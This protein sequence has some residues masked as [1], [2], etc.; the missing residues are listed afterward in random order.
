MPVRRTYIRKK[1][2]KRR[3][4]GLPSWSDKLLQEVLRQILDA[5]YEPRFSQHS[6]GFRPGRGCHTALQEMTQHWRGVKWYVEGDICSFFDRIDH[7]ILVKILRE[8]IHDNRFIG[9]I[10]HLLQ[11]GYMEE[12][13]FN[14]TLSGVPQ[15]GVV[16]P[17]LSNL[18]LD[19]LDKYVETVLT[20]AYTRGKRRK[21]SPPYVKLTKDAWKAKKRGDR[22]T[23]RQLNKQAQA[24][25]SRDPHAPKFRRLWYCRYADDWL[26][27]FTGPKAEAE[28]IK[29]HLAHFLREELGLELSEEKT[30]ITH[31]RSDVA[32]FLGYEIHTLQADDKHDHRGQRCING[33]L[34][35]RVPKAVIQAKC[36]KY[37]R[38]GKP[39]HLPQRL[40]DTPY[41]IVV[42]YQ[43][44][45]RGLVQDYRLAY[46]LHQLAKLKRVMEVSLAKTLA[47]KLKTSCAAIF[48]RFKTEQTNAYGTYK[49]LEVRV[50]RGPDKK[51]LVAH[52]GGIPL[53]WSKWVSISETIEP[54][55]SQRSEVVQ[56]LLAEK[57]ELCGATAK[58]EAH[59]I[60][61]LADLTLKGRRE[62][63]KWAQQMIARRRKSLMVCQKCHHDIHS[64]RYNGPSFSRR[65]HWRAT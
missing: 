1:S 51:P 2:G 24:M 39:V 52:F 25:P 49:V 17:I 28:E 32:H 47:N 58:L 10:D 55:W 18:M 16:S 61:K 26:I 11:A 63:P 5:Y 29:H 44:E 43:A 38:H 42:Q 19:K 60:R 6:H 54:I 40:N 46:H 22:E 20:P 21:T 13:R 64:G 9:L 57:C 34:G 36:A 8:Q 31:A 50:E 56:R 3:P 14:T 48:K 7:T 35:L 53:Q 62:Q 45:Y 15:G 30:L 65:G 41:S 4:L 23:A 12:W 33:A 37:L 59:H 27:G